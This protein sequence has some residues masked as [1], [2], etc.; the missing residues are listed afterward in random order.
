MSEVREEVVELDSG[1]TL[2]VR[3]TDADLVHEGGAARAGAVLVHGLASN[4][5]MWDAC[6]QALAAGGVTSVAPDLRG[7]GRT[8][9]LARGGRPTAPHGAGPPD[10]PAAAGTPAAAA[11]VAALVAHYQL[12]GTLPPPVVLAGQSWGGNVVL[13]AAAG[14]AGPASTPSPWSTAAGCA[15][16]ATSR[17]S[18]CG[19]GWPRPAGT[20]RP[21]EQAE[22]RIGS[23]VAGWGP[24]ALPAIMANL[25]TDASGHVRNVLDL[26]AHEQI[27]RSMHEADPRALYPAVTR[28]RAARPGG[29]RAGVGAARRGARGPARPAPAPLRRRPP[30]PAPAAPASASPPTCSPCSTSSRSP[31]CPRRTQ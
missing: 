13:T 10:D 3:V 31:R 26:A 28:P 8:A 27:L 20:A 17:S 29:R 23:M 7:H 24:H 6:A 25:T 14:H 12:D 16:R 2:A 30:R 11:D 22:E 19:P 9:A 15:S 5:R 21:W 1:A 18:G 4:A